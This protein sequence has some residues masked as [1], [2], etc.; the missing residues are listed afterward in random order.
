MTEIYFP[1][2]T[3]EEPNK[4]SYIAQPISAFINMITCLI[5][6]YFFLQAKT[7][8][9]RLLIL[10]FILFEIFHTFSHITHIDGTIQSN[11]IHGIWYFLSFMVL[12]ASIKITKQYPNIYTILILLTIIIIDINLFFQ[13]NKLYMVFTALTLPV[14]IVISYYNLY[15]ICIKKAI[16]YLIALL[17]ILGLVLINEKINCLN[18][19]KYAKLPYH[20]IIEIIGMIL[21]TLLSYI[22]LQTEKYNL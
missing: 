19:M 8:I 21:F 13:A 14:V 12:I 6:I 7:L 9:I 17:I 5:L 18:M 16:P 22:F 10:S 15:P 3:C 11:I 2:N 20:A 1:F 4:K